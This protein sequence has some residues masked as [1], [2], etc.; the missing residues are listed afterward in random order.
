MYETLGLRASF[1]SAVTKANAGQDV[2]NNHLNP[3]VLY[4]MLAAVVLFF[5]GELGSVNNKVLKTYS[6]CISVRQ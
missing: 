3:N 4:M 5:F 2:S 6:L 1:L